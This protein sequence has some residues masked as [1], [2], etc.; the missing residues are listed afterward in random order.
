MGGPSRTSNSTTGNVLLARSYASYDELSRA[1]QRQAELFMPSGV[2]PSRPVVLS[3]GDLTPGDGRVTNFTD[4]D[5]SSRVTFVTQASPANA[6]EQSRTFYDGLSRSIKVVDP[7]G[8]EVQ[9]VYDKNSNAVKVTVIEKHPTGRIAPQTFVTLNV[10]DSLNRLSRT[11]DTL[12]QT[13]RFYY[14]SRN[15][16]IRSSDAQGPAIADPLGLFAGQINADGN[17]SETV[18]DGLGR[19][20]WTMRQLTTDGQG[21]S[22]LDTT[23]PTNPDGKII[24]TKTWD[25]NSRLV[26]VADDKGNMTAYQY[27][28]LNRRLTTTFADGTATVSVFDKDSNLIRYTDNNGSVIDGSFDAVGRLVQ[29][30]ITPAADNGVKGTTLQTFEYDGLSRITRATDNNDPANL[31]DDS[32]VS[33]LYDSFSRMIEEQQNG[34]AISAN[35]TQESTPVDLTYPNGRKLEYTLDKLNRLK[36]ITSGGKSIANYDYI[37]GR[38]IEKIL[39]NA[40]KLTLLN[41][42][43]SADEGH[44]AL[45]RLVKMRHVGPSANLLAGFEYTY[46]R[47]NFKTATKDLQTSQLSEIYK[48]DSVYRIVDFKRGTLNAQNDGIEGTPVNTQAW[49]LDGVGNWANTV[50]DGTTQTQVANNMN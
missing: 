48:L 50:V 46:N 15:L 43:G 21:G 17:V 3:E 31:E 38:M 1:Y 10:F 13:R 12:G 33:R 29:R 41:D 37:G 47:E 27:D 39:G 32:T 19:V 4:Y 6:L 2:A 11:T 20:L 42:A 7:D 34:K 49:A 35:W 22:P 5:R 45:G 14:D 18:H 8:N 24:E 23:N 30:M 36:S 25:A 26:S 44:D 40:T 28:N 16:L 9:T